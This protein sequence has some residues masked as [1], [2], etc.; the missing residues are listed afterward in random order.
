MKHQV[1]SIYCRGNILIKKFR[2]C[3]DDV[4]IKLF[5]SYCSS[6]YGSNLWCSFYDYNRQKLV[7]AYKQIFRSFFNCKREGTTFQMLNYSIQP[8]DVLE[9]KCLHGFMERILNCDNVIVA[10]VVNATFFRS[11]KFFYHCSKILYAWFL[12]YLFI[13]IVNNCIYISSSMDMYVLLMYLSEI[14]VYYII[15]LL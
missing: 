5:K 7:V 1:R 12:L 15:I 8:F 2:H 13:V 10:C 14:K 4:K 6:F 9:R 3:S 11:T